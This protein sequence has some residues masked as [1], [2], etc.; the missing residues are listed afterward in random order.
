M[1]RI[2]AFFARSL[3]AAGPIALVKLPLRLTREN[4][5]NNNND[6]MAHEDTEESA[7]LQSYGPC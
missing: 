6:I 5:S 3:F 7:G 2:R 1:A 4:Y